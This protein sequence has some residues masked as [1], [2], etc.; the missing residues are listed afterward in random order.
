MSAVRRNL[1]CVSGGVCESGPLV[2]VHLPCQKWLGGLV[3][4]NVGSAAE[5]GARLGVADALLLHLA[6][7]D[8]R[9]LPFE[10]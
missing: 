3:N 7:V 6:Q 10:C 1:A 5:L 9:H 8:D 4:L 2:A